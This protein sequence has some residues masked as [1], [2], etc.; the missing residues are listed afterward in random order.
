M[1]GEDY[2]LPIVGAG[3]TDPALEV[4]VNG[5]VAWSDRGL[6]APGRRTWSG[7]V[8]APAGGW[9]AARVGGGAVRWP[10]MDSYPFAHTGAPW[11]GRVGSTDPESARAAARDLLAL[12][13]VA[14]E[15]LADGYAGA[16]IP[17]LRERF[18]RARRMLEGLSG[19]SR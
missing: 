8:R 5:Q 10:V 13:D 9:M 4:I 16:E 12:M 15:R 1:G 6:D 19:A 11:F 3:P 2:D 17:T 7:S 14:D 18:A